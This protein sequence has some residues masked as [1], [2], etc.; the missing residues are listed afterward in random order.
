[1]D[2]QNYI[3]S[4]QLFSVPIYFRSPKEHK[5][6]FAQKRQKYFESNKD[7]YIALDEEITEKDVKM[8]ELDFARKLYHP[9]KYTE[10]IGFIEF[11]KKENSIFT[12]VNLPDAQR[13][14]PLMNNK[15]FRLSRDFPNYEIDITEMTNEEIV[16]QIHNIIDQVG[17]SSRRFR[18]YYIDKSEMI[19]FVHLIDYHTI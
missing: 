14:A 3:G 19:N 4:K 9:W 12:F 10:I 11:R 6:E 5:K 15:R 18:R 17:K 16:E 8:W 7:I 1:M 13:Y 2:F